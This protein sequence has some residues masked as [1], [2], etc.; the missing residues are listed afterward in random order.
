MTAK[1]KDPNVLDYTTI[2]PLRDAIF[3]YTRSYET[4][5]GDHAGESS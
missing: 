2:P 1:K 4:G 5:K 3:E